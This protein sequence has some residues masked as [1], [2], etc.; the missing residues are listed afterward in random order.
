M[1]RNSKY[2][3]NR[4]SQIEEM[5]HLENEVAAAEIGKQF[6]IAQKDIAKEINAWY[7]RL[8]DNNGVSIEEA[9]KLLNAN[10]LKEFKWDVDQY[11]KYGEENAL[12]GNWMKELENASAKVHISRL[13]EINLRIKAEKYCRAD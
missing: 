5:N 2:W 10:E 7:G 12:N 4:Y 11:I 1:S 8:A 3:Q 6:D 9:R 13:E